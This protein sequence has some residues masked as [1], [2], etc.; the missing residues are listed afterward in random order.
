MTIVST[1]LYEDYTRF[2]KMRLSRL[3]NLWPGKLCICVHVFLVQSVVLQ[4]GVNLWSDAPQS[5]MKGE[6]RRDNTSH[7]K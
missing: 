2:I 4:G 3:A 6:V 1:T 5:T 7:S